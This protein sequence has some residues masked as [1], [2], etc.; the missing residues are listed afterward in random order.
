LLKLERQQAPNQSNAL[1][2]P[3]IWMMNCASKPLASWFAPGADSE[4]VDVEAGSPLDRMFLIVLLITTITILSR[5]KLNWAVIKANS[6]W[7]IILCG[8]ALVSILWSEFIFVSIKRYIRFCGTPLIAM[9][10]LSEASPRLAMESVLR[11]TAFVLVP[12]SI[13]LIKYLPDR[14]V[15][16]GRWSGELMWV[17]V[18]SQKNALGILCFVS[19]FF[20]LWRTVRAFSER[21]PGEKWSRKQ[22]LYIAADLSVLAIAVLLLKGP[23]KAYSATSLVVSFVGV[24]GLLALMQMR[25]RK[26][27]V[28]VPALYT[29]VVLCFIYGMGIPFGAATVSSGFME[30]LGRDATFTDRDQIWRELVPIAMQ[31]SVLGQGYGGFWVRPIESG[32][33]EAHNGYLDLM[34]ELG[35][36]GIVLLFAFIIAL[37]KAA[38]RCLPQDFWWSSLTICLTIMTLVHNSTESSFL[39]TSN[40]LW[41]LLVI[42][43]LLVSVPQ[44]APRTTV[45]F[46]GSFPRSEPRPG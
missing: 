4:G 21:K 6:F 33:N 3:T 39:K 9:I 26:A 35:F 13:V 34:L 14:G 30:A 10:I 29:V 11:R 17:G 27:Y 20:L 5:R 22:K 18:T 43:Y 12:F 2:V 25:K 15:M 45:E 28:P 19:A 8:Y 38:Y 32:V 7:L 36:V 42:L 40:F 1:W 23:G 46:A 37:C 44:K 24:S 16:Y 41:S 31:N